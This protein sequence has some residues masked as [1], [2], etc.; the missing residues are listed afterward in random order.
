[1]VEVKYVIDCD[2]GHDDAVA[3]LYGA[4]HA[5][6]LGITTVFGNAPVEHTTRNALRICDLAALELPVARGMGRP[7]VGEAVHASDAHGVTGLD[8]VELPEPVRQPIAQHAVDYLIEQAGVHPDALVIVAVGPLSNIAAALHKEPRMAEWLRGIT[9]MG[10]STHI[11][12][13]TPVAET[14]I[15]ADPEAAHVVLHSGIPLHMVGLNVTREVGVTPDDIARLRQSGHRVAPKIAD[16]LEFY[17]QRQQVLYARDVAPMHDVCAWMPYLHPAW[18]Q[19]REAHVEVELCGRYTRGMTVC[20]LRG[21]RTH[22]VQKIT[23]PAEANVHVALAADRNAIIH[24]VV[25]TL[26]GYD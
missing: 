6:V 10:G 13:M 15:A 3:I 23:P 21:L 19:Y 12:N 24:A 14:N 5:E 25:E 20:D 9:I 16:L 26:L 11:G 7:L 1:M 22:A 18:M 4:A 2:P 8:G 17:R